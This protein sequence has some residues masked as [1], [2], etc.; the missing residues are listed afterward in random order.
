MM[1]ITEKVRQALLRGEAVVAP[2]FAKKIGCRR[3]NVRAAI[4]RLGP[5]V[6]EEVVRGKRGSATKVYTAKDV[7]AL[8]EWKPATTA[9]KFGADSFAALT[10]AFHM[11]VVKIKLPT[12][13]HIMRGNWA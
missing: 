3:D 10:E 13:R 11:R 2:D 4:R 7:R 6:S 12:H 8:E 1:T 9:G 5:A